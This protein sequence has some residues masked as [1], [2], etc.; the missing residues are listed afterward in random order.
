M[1]YQLKSFCITGLKGSIK[2]RENQQE[3]K[4]KMG[5]GQMQAH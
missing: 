5:R 2:H 1:F 3:S 4:Q